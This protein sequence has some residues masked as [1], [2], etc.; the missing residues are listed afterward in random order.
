MEV[1]LFDPPVLESYLPVERGRQTERPMPQP[2]FVLV[3][4]STS[5]MVQSNAM[6]LGK[7]KL[8]DVPLT[9]SVT[10]RSL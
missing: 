5:R 4:P 10:I 6:S 8:R 7:S 2:N 3:M 1:G 9:L